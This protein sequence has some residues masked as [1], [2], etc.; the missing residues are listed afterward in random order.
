MR[1]LLVH[2]LVPLTQWYLARSRTFSS[3][4][5]VMEIPKGVF[6]PGLFFS[7]KFLISYLNT[8]NL[9]N[10]NLLELGAGSGLISIF[11]Q[12]KGAIVTASD[13]NQV[14]IHQLAINAEKNQSTL[15]IV[16]SDLF[17]QLKQ[18]IFDW[19][20]INPPYYPR[21]PKNEEEHAWYCG[22]KFEYFYQLAKQLP[23][24]IHHNSRII[25]VLSEDCDLPRI[26]KILTQQGI[27]MEL[28]VKKE[29][30]L[31]ENYIFG[32]KVT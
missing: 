1:R 13:I 26:Q 17:N 23:T 19:V 3:Y 2:I 28:L 31:E 18:R 22:E 20:I 5:I 7:T 4:G 10:Q 32:L 27:V 30:W 11:C 21:N 24:H 15:E 14:A 29:F 16:Q 8:K 25:M 6:H 12:K 9:A